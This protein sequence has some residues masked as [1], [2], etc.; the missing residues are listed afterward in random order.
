M[1]RPPD[2]ALLASNDPQLFKLSARPAPHC[3]LVTCAAVVSRTQADPDV[4]PG[5][6]AV[7]D[8]PGSPRGGGPAS[9]SSRSVQQLLVAAS[10]GQTNEPFSICGSTEPQSS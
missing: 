7:T 2:R 3:Q 4:S 5:T 8:Q 6:P 10:A 9:D 1:M